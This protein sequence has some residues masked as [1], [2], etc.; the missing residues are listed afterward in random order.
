MLVILLN[1]KAE[2]K[3]SV[4]IAAYN[5]AG[6]LM[7][8]INSVLDQDYNNI[9]LIVVDDC[10]SDDTWAVLSSVQSEKLR[11]YRNKTNLGVYKTLNIGLKNSTGDYIC[12][13]DADDQLLPGSIKLRI[14]NIISTNSDAVHTSLRLVKDGEARSVPPIDTT[15]ITNTLDFLKSGRSNKGINNATLMFERSILANIGYID[16]SDKYFPHSDFEFAL[17]IIAN[18]KVSVLDVD[19]YEYFVHNASHSQVHG[20]SSTSDIKFKALKK[21]YINMLQKN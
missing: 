11:S 5:Y 16:E 9:E 6:K 20:A 10:S 8:S 21:H 4:I 12:F 13:L 14:E 7:C 18:S 19:T 15:R 3:V 1:M 17:R 2:P